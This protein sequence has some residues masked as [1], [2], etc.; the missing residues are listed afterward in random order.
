MGTLPQT[1]SQQL[2]TGLAARAADVSRSSAGLG[3]AGVA[4]G[5]RSSVFEHK[6][7]NRVR[8]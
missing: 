1:A 4:A 6:F 7:E 8:G 2:H 5:T 3:R